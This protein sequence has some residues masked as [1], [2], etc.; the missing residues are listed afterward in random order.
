M[1]YAQQG[2]SHEV[3]QFDNAFQAFEAAASRSGLMPAT[4]PA[5]APAAEAFD[6]CAQWKSARGTVNE[7]IAA[8]RSVETLFP[9]AK[10]AADIIQT[11][12]T[13]LDQVCG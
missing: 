12:A 4:A 6:P 10:K 9:I 2:S 1:S 13:L 3:E 11:L 5:T 7:V 8:L